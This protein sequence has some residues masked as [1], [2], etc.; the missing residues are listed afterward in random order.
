MPAFCLTNS[1][2]PYPKV[3]AKKRNECLEENCISDSDCLNNI[4]KPI[5][6]SFSYQCIGCRNNGQCL[7]KNANKPYCMNTGACC[8]K[9]STICS[10]K[11]ILAR[12]DYNRIESF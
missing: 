6:D 10:G 5:C 11:Y 4:R 1:D 7:N 2:C 8:S 9:N 12:L 3:C